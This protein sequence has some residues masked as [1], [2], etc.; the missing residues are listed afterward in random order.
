M[1][2]SSSTPG[3]RGSPG[4]CPSKIVEETGTLAS[5]SI[6]RLSRSSA[7]TR[8]ISWK[9]SRRMPGQALCLL[10]RNQFVN[11]S[12]QVVHDEILVSRRFAFVD[13]L[14]PLFNWHLDPERLIDRKGDIEKIE[15][16]DPEIVNG[17]ALR[18]D[19][20][21]R[22]VTGLGND[23]YYGIECRRHL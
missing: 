18:L 22:N 23:V 3:I 7:T 5:T 19:R 1:A 20:V 8:S 14:G 15:A 16:V 11:A 12:A 4:K 6:V 13:L 9:Y 21:T 17:M 10:G 2:S